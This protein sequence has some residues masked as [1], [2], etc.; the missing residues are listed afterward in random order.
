V[1]NGVIHGPS[2]FE[3]I[4]EGPEKQQRPEELYGQGHLE[5]PD[6][7]LHR[8]GWSIQSKAA[9]EKEP[10][11]NADFCSPQK[12]Q[13][14]E[15]RHDTQTPQLDQDEDDPLR[16]KGQVA[17]RVNHNQPCD[18]DRRGCRKKGINNPKG[19]EKKIPEP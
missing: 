11:T 18:T 12:R 17:P 10:L 4:Q 13:R 5:N 19:L 6:E 2:R 8:A 3:V 14:R 9:G 16:E 15:S 7:Q 1:K